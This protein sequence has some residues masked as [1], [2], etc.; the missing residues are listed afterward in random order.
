MRRKTTLE[1]EARDFFSLVVESIHMNPFLDDR[2]GVLRQISPGWFPGMTIAPEL[3]AHIERLDSNGLRKIQDFREE[4][5]RMVEEVFLYQHFIRL[6]PDFRKMIEIQET[7]PDSQVTAPFAKRLIGQLQS[8]GFSETVCWH[9]LA[10]FYQLHRAFH[11]ISH[12][13]IGDCPAMKQLRYSLWNNVFTYD[14][15]LYDR[16][17][18]NRLEDFSTLLLG[19]TGTGKGSA[20]LAIGRSGFIPFDPRKGQ[21]T[22]NL[23]ETFVSI[24]LSQ[25]PESLIESE[26]FGHRKGAFT[27]AVENHEGMFA[28][29]SVHG[30]LFLDE[31]GDIAIPIQIKLLQV[32]EERS[33]T[34]VG[35]HEL[36]RFQGRVI[37]A[38]NRSIGELRKQG[39]F[40]DDLFYRLCSDVIIVPTLRQRIEESPSELELMVNLLITRITG[41]E[42]P[43]LTDM[44]ME[45]LKRDLPKDYRWPGN[46]RELGQAVRRILL[47]QHYEGDILVSESNLEEKTIEGIRSGSLKA[48][49]LL[50]QYCSLLYKR[51]GT[52]QEVARRAGLDARTV[53]KYLQD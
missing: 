28:R 15:G 31:I 23:M 40:R 36:K 32:L 14:L 19:E 17:L 41:G 12:A 33:F 26:L 50:N 53:K 49:E 5:R 51:F 29:C 21:F 11:F 10:L 35:S 38:T 42:N 52:Y 22:H 8:R 43:K 4:D 25:Y 1:G 45:T 39:N 9:R 6:A 13:L 18:F 2:R 48:N 3:D 24:N 46:V 27:G 7:S 47:T 37:A 34:P 30:A 44:V 20:A 16:Y